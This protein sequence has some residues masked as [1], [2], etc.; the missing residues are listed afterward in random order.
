[1]ANNSMDDL[2]SFYEKKAEQL[3]KQK[4]FEEALLFSQ[5]AK[6]IRDDEKF[7]DYWYKK[8]IHFVEEGEFENAIE[9][10]DN[11][12]LKYQKSYRTFLAKGKVLLQ[13]QRYDEALECF[14]KAAEEK[15]LNYLQTSKKVLHLKKARK[16]EKALIYSSKASR[17][18]SSDPEFWYYKGIS[19]LKLKKYGDAHSCMVNAVNLDGSNSKL[20]YELAKCELFLGNESSCIDLLQKSIRIK[21]IMKEMLQVDHDFSSL[22]KNNKFRAIIHL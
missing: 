10:F 20:L 22:H 13:L 2:E 3:K 12:I 8:G 16:F 15:N 18:F 9:C 21:P 19:L 7:P 4:K 6:Q 11:D 1:M 14:N 17:E 5:K